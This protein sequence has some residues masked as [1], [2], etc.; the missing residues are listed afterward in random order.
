[1]TPRKKKT[2]RELIEVNFPQYESLE[3]IPEAQLKN[4]LYSHVMSMVLR[5]E[6]SE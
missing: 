4:F 1:M 5:E 3:K 2:W 6:T